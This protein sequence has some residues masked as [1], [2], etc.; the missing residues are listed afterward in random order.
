MTDFNKAARNWDSNNIHVQRSEAIVKLMLDRLPFRTEMKALEFGAGTGILSFML[1]ERLGSITMMDS[2]SEMVAVMQEKV[3]ATG[4]RNLKPVLFDLTVQPYHLEKF[5]L[6]FSQ[7]ALHHVADIQALFY[8]FH[9]L[10]NNDGYLAIADLYTEDGSFHGEGFD[11]HKGFD[12]AELE[13]QLKNAGFHS[14]QTETCFS[15]QKG[16]NSYPIFLMISRN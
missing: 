14:I 15:M 5:D 10:M 16:A 11:G 6:I 3:D 2:A 4:D 12:V 13:A 9:E 7:M 1:A 8:R